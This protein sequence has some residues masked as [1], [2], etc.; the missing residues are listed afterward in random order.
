MV[1]RSS[2]SG[3]CRW[4]CV[5]YKYQF[6]ENKLHIQCP[7]ICRVYTS[8]GGFWISSVNSIFHLAPKKPCW[9]LSR[10]QIHCHVSITIFWWRFAG[11]FGPPLFRLQVTPLLSPLLGTARDCAPPPWARPVEMFDE[12]L[13]PVFEEFKWPNNANIWRK[14]HK[15]SVG[16]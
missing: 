3:T 7:I 9:H 10:C 11:G 13:V 14:Q 15:R 4:S 1:G 16:L 6:T 8:G 2:R 12:N 5:C